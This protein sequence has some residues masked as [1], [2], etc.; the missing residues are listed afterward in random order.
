VAAVLAVRQ[1]LLLTCPVSQTVYYLFTLRSVLLLAAC[2]GGRFG[3]ATVFVINVS[4][5]SNSMLRVP[6][7]VGAAVVAAVLAVQHS[8]CRHELVRCI[9]PHDAC[10][11]SG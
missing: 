6:S 3:S 5:V 8:P 4:G 10:L 11:L 2:C 1:F 9:K 7:Q